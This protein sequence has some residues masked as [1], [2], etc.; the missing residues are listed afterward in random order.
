M[1]GVEDHTEYNGGG[2]MP[3]TVFPMGPDALTPSDKLR[4]QSITGQEIDSQAPVDP[5]HWYGNL[6]PDESSDRQV[7]MKRRQRHRALRNSERDRYRESPY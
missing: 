6:R 3:N 5:Y 7:Q 2:V 1:A 4:L